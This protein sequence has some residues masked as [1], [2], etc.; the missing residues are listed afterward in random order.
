MFSHATLSLFWVYLKKK[1]KW[2][3]EK[4]RDMQ[5]NVDV[6]NLKADCKL[7]DFVEHCKLGQTGIGKVYTAKEE[8]I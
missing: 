4:K 7:F 8:T 1:K 6:N 5:S 3:K 2:K